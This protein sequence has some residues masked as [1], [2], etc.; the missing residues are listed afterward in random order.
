M[1]LRDEASQTER[2]GCAAR[3][4]NMVRI[5]LS[6]LLAA[7]V[8]LPAISSAQAAE[9]SGK[10]KIF[11]SAENKER[12]KQIMQ[13]EEGFV[14]QHPK[15]TLDIQRVAWPWYTSF[16]TRLAGGLPPDLWLSVGMYGS[17]L[18]INQGV[19][20]DLDPLIARDKVNTGQYF[21]NVLDYTTHDGIRYGLPIAMFTDAVI[22]NVDLFNEAGL[23]EPPHDYEDTSW[24]WDKYVEYGR[25]L[26][27]DK[28]GDGKPET[29]G[30]D[31]I[32]H[33]DNVAKSYGGFPFSSDFKKAEFTSPG[34]VSAY[35]LAQDV[36]HKYRVS[37]TYDER[38]AQNLGGIAFDKG[39]A[40]MLIDFT[41]RAGNYVNNKKLNFDLAAK[42]RGPAG[43][44]VLLYLN[45]I[46]IVANAPNPEAAW[47]YAKY[48]TRPDV[49]PSLAVYGYNA[50]P[51]TREGALLFVKR[52][53]EQRPNVD[54]T[55]FVRGAEHAFP[56]EYWRPNYKEIDA[57]VE[58][59]S[60]QILDNKQNVV[61]GLQ[62]LDAQV[63]AILDKYWASQKKK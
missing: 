52:M 6:G 13:V 32:G 36:V 17:N 5:V 45:T 23:A 55:V 59:I 12:T 20:K 7:A 3:G 1:R 18:Y 54:W 48:V 44:S 33:L 22:Y 42:P 30:I 63:Q 47:E 29:W 49:M 34:V 37:P 38:I 40:G 27:R 56:V 57:A 51:P 39:V 4:S 21:K 28:N 14:K 24:T 11:A 46:N 50:I 35:R 60:G 58:A 53:K 61:T 16:E 8:L 9:V 62:G 43:P 41:V 19:W 31:G 2:Y 26:T 10:L 25:K 15:V